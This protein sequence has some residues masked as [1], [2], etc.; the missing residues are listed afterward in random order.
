VNIVLLERVLNRVVEVI[1]EDTPRLTPL[2]VENNPVCAFSVLP[3][4][5]EKERVLVVSVEVTRE[6]TTRVEPAILEV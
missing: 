3:A 5:V 2:L 1:I 6:D 4:M